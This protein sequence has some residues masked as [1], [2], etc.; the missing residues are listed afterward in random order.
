MRVALIHYWLTSD[1]GGEKVLRALCDLFPQADI[2]THVYDDDF[3]NKRFP[4]HK[5]KTTFIGSLPFAKKRY[6]FY[7]PLMP[8]ALEEL[9]LSEYDLVISSESGPA[10]GVIASPGAYHVC[11]C[12]SPMRYVWDQYS[13]YKSQASPLKRAVMPML[14]SSL[15]QWDYASAARVDTFVA[16]SNLVA[17]RIGKYYRRDATV[18]HP[19]VNVDLFDPAVHGLKDDDLSDTYLWAGQLVPYKRPDIAVKAFTQM[20]KKLLVIGTGEEERRLRAMAGPTVKFA[21]HVSLEE[22]Q[23]AYASCKALIFPGLED[24][25]IVPVEAMAS[26]TPVI[27]LGAGGALDTVVDGK[28]GVLFPSATIDHLVDAIERFEREAGG[29]N[30]ET[31]SIHAKRFAAPSFKSNFMAAI[32]SG[33]SKARPGNPPTD[34]WTRDNAGSSR[35]PAQV[36]MGY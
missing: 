32:E 33:L 9:D 24:F 27:A 21:G 36:E 17:Q 30:K 7:L 16:N 20:G 2:F 34:W 8:M 31:I 28:T 15:R 11:Y 18:V 29:F 22:L 12:H 1:R 3:V 13:V 25:G 5:I 4:G 19:P 26:G 35:R 14:A 23:T 10:K 6:Q